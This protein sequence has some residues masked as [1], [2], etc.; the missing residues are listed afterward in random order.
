MN[1]TYS[2]LGHH[3]VMRIRCW[4]NS[5]LELLKSVL[6]LFGAFF[7]TFMFCICSNQLYGF[8]HNAVPII[9]FCG[10]AHILEGADC[11]KKYHHIMQNMKPLSWSNCIIPSH[12]VM[13][14]KFYILTSL[15]AV[16]WHQLFTIGYQLAT[17]PLWKNYF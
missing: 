14:Q 6:H 15:D 13:M 3:V 10:V 17:E 12:Y 8:Q 2:K 9:V 1:T 7:V 16:I 5:L 4:Y 11:R